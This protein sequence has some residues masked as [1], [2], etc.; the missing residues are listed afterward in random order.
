MAIPEIQLEAWSHQGPVATALKACASVRAA[1]DAFDQ[2]PD[3]VWLEPYLRGSYNNDTNISGDSDV[4]L[5]VQLNSTFRTNL[6]SEQKAAYKIRPATYP[7]RELRKDV[8]KAFT[9][10]YGEFEVESKGNA[11]MVMTS[12]PPTAV[13]PALAYRRYP[14]APRNGDD[15]AEGMIYYEFESKRWVVDYP[16]QHAEGVTAKQK[17]THGWF[18]P[19]VRVFKNIRWQLLEVGALNINDASS[20]F[21]ECLLGN[22]PEGKFGPTY[23]DTVAE[24]HDWLVQ[25][26]M[27]PFKCLNG[28]TPLFGT[29]PDCW[30][31]K[32]ALRFLAAVR[33]L[34]KQWSQ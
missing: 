26:D 6:S 32:K 13:I 33:A 34:W 17:A 23:G 29:T 18:K 22:V 24:S 4:D 28:I 21:I 31:T 14:A 30:S 27:A 2:W 3:D 25:A 10:Y 8:R 9:A 15:Y 12:F 5:V 19:T 7:L 1:L 11:I 20:Y 16:K